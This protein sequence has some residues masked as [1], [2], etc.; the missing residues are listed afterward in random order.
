M[1]VLNSLYIWKINKGEE[2]IRI[3]KPLNINFSHLSVPLSQ[4]LT[5]IACL[6]AALHL[7]TPYRDPIQMLKNEILI[8]IT[9]QCWVKLPIQAVQRVVVK[10]FF[11]LIC[12]FDEGKWD[13][14]KSGQLLPMSNL[15]Y[16]HKSLYFILLF[17]K[18]CIITAWASDVT[19][20]VKFKI[21]INK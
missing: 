14:C 13:G 19:S 20:I 2:S 18:I 16:L 10:F 8:L 1:Y 9:L 15:F 12:W 5:N 6:I 11:F 17:L 21:S 4:C 7:M 3:S